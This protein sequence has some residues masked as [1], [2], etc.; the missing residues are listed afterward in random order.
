MS[1]DAVPEEVLE[2]LRGRNFVHSVILF[3][4]GEET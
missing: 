3:G 1:M 4:S 2:V